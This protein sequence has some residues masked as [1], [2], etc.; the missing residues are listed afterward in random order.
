MNFL[1]FVDKMERLGK[2]HG[3]GLRDGFLLQWYWMNFG[4]GL[5][6]FNPCFQ[7]ELDEMNFR[8]VWR[9]LSPSP[10][11]QQVGTS[12]ATRIWKAW[13]APSKSISYC[14]LFKECHF[15]SSQRGPAHKEWNQLGRALVF[16]TLSN[17]K[18]LVWNMN[19]RVVPMTDVP[20]ACTCL[21]VRKAAPARANMSVQKVKPVDFIHSKSVI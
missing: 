19:L 10:I 11:N 3:I 2:T 21:Q 8:C 17:I 18:E 15:L 7:R 1:L 16:F 20:A 13:D 5:V 12:D 9:H 4:W 14:F 6:A